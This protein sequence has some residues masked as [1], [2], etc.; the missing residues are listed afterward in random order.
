MTA[1][2]LA[3]TLRYIE[4]LNDWDAMIGPSYARPAPVMPAVARTSKARTNSGRK[5]RVAPAKR[6]AVRRN[7]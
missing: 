5:S 7:P 3:S 6:K 2:N 1:K 4:S